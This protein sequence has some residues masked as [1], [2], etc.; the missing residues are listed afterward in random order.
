MKWKKV[1]FGSIEFDDYPEI[2]PETD[3]GDY[4]FVPVKCWGP[5]FRGYSSYFLDPEK[6]QFEIRM[7][8]EFVERSFCRKC[9][10]GCSGLFKA[11]RDLVDDPDSVCWSTIEEDEWY[12]VEVVPVS[13]VD[14]MSDDLCEYAD[15]IRYQM[16]IMTFDEKFPPK[17]RRANN[18]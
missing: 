16:E 5:L 1:Q 13:I 11:M 17:E 10:D 2:E 9:K 12:T 6:K 14:F 3:N 15:P 4:K 18:E 7:G 8:I